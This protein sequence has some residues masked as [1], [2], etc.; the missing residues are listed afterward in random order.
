[1]GKAGMQ[2][3]GDLQDSAGLG[4]R[5]AEKRVL[6]LDARVCCHQK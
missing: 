4:K 6:N 3:A 5:S 2:H 1:V